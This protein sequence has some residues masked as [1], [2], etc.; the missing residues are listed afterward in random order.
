VGL[1]D[2]THLCKNCGNLV[3]PQA[4]SK[5]NGCFFVVLLFFFVIPGILYLFWAGAQ[6]VYTCPKCK[7]QNCFV[8]L[9]S[10]EAQRV[11]AGLSTE[12]QTQSG[13]IE[14]ACPWCAEPILA[15][16]RVCK[17]CGRD[18][19]PVVDSGEAE[20]VDLSQDAAEVSTLPA[21]VPGG[22][23][24]CGAFDALLKMTSTGRL[25]RSCIEDVGLSQDAAEVS[26]L[27][28]AVPGGCERCGAF[29]ALL[30][31]TSA[32]RLCRSC[33]EEMK[34]TGA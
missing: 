19:E 25:C 12:G 13:R 8:P 26:T 27:P 31:M 24:R 4:S 33:I 21:P 32:G 1:F 22:C 28:A 11:R 10:P 7:A 20:P 17:H 5:L 30:K 6:R 15:A 14:R 9:D 3:R 2:P 29:D 34:A 16:A 23:E 18:V